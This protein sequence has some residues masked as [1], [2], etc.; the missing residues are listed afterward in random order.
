MAEEVGVEK[1][2]VPIVEK[3]AEPMAKKYSDEDRNAFELKAKGE[4]TANLLKELGV[5]STGKLKEDMK[6]LKKIQDEGK[7][8]AE[9]NAAAA[10]DATDGK[11]AAERRADIAEMKIEALTLGVD[12]TRLDDLIILAE[13]E[14][15]ATIAEKVK[16][17][18]EKR[19]WLKGE[20]KP[21]DFGGKVKGQ[22]LDERAKLQAQI[23]EGFGI[24]PAK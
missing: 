12:K 22:T 5:E 13:K 19:P 15:G 7:T 11:T 20:D 21:A 3:P 1:P 16:N 23:N 14:E 10:K 24:K 17:A 8:E 9:R 6:L 18:I 2:V 4:A